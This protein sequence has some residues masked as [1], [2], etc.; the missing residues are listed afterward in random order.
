MPRDLYAALGRPRN[1]EEV[2]RMGRGPDIPLPRTASQEEI[3]VAVMAA[4]RRHHPDRNP[5]DPDGAGVRFQN[6][7]VARDILGDAEKR[8]VYDDGLWIDPQDPPIG[9][10]EGVPGWYK[11]VSD[12]DRRAVLSGAVEAACVIGGLDK[13]AASLASDFVIGAAATAADAI[14]SPEP[15]R[16]RVA[17]ALGVAA[18]KFSHPEGR[19]AVRSA[20]RSVLEAWHNLFGSGKT[21][22]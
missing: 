16:K 3:E 22:T 5:S 7:M 15:V 12:P 17:T 6:A 2:R 9:S 14:Q 4:I 21:S 20:G 8:K 1:E 10:G 18:Q 11:A 13:D 19:A